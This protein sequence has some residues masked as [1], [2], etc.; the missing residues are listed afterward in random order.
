MEKTGALYSLVVVVLGVF[1]CIAM[2]EKQATKN[3]PTDRLIANLE[4]QLESLEAGRKAGA[5]VCDQIQPGETL[6]MTF[7]DPQRVVRS[8]IYRVA[9]DG[10]VY[11]A[12]SG[13][14]RMAGVTMFQ[15]NGEREEEL[16]RAF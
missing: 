13:G 8:R 10:M 6:E 9:R 5:L 2:V 11:I 7:V 1:Q 14:V 15:L 3:V 12:G 4:R 16:R